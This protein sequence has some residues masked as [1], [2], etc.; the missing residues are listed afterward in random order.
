[1][2]KGDIKVIDLVEDDFD[3]EPEEDHTKA[4]DRNVPIKLSQQPLPSIKDRFFL[5]KNK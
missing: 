1:M 4:K 3:F 2:T 5:N